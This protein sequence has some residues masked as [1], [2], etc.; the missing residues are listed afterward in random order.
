MLK[1]VCY[2][3][4]GMLTFVISLAVLAIVPP[5]FLPPGFEFGSMSAATVLAAGISYL[6]TPGIYRKIAG[7]LKRFHI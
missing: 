3:V 1:W 7:K 2:G 4:I 6:C 5:L